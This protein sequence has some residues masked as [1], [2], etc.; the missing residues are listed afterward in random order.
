MSLKTGMKEID[1][2]A[3]DVPLS[4]LGLPPL[5]SLSSTVMIL[6]VLNI[7]QEKKMGSLTFIEEDKLVGILT[8]KDLLLRVVGKIE[9]WR[10][11]PAS[12]VMTKDPLSITLDHTVAEAIKMMSKM[13]FRHVPIVDD[14]GRP[15]HMVSVT[16][17]LKF[18]IKFFPDFVEKQGTVVDWDIF[19]FE[20]FGEDFSISPPSDKG[21]VSGSIFMTPLKRIRNQSAPCLDHQ[22]PLSEVLEYMQERR[23]SSLIITEYDSKIKGV[24]TERDLLMKVLSSEV[25]VDL[26][27]IL[28]CDVMTKDPHMLSYKHYLC[29][30]INN[31]FTFKYRNLIV[32]DEDRFPIA[33]IRLLDILKYI[34]SYLFHE[35]DS[36]DSN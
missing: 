9:N 26:T 19:S 10:D 15:I 23:L 3:F 13:E 5:I 17:I 7:L 14:E 4:E 6:D 16:D 33:I 28:V 22:L 27:K 35:G 30:G 29:H 1:N 2:N 20:D 11:L 8:E 24:F 18:I 36:S 32:V 31:M 12:G 25:K 21:K 34:A